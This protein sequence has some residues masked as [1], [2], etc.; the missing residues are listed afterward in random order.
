MIIQKTDNGIKIMRE[1][2]RII[3]VI[4]NEIEKKIKPG[5]S[6]Y[7][8]DKWAE[9]RIL[10]LNALPGFKGYGSKTRSFPATLCTSIN[11]EVVHGIPSENVKLLPVPYG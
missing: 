1:A 6:T 4:L 2:N 5:V 11:Y 10:S 9:E 8:L 7:E 3:A